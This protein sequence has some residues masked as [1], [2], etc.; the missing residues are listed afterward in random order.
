MKIVAYQ[1]KPA[2]YKGMYIVHSFIIIKGTV[3]VI[4][5]Y[6]PLMRILDSQW[7][8]LKFDLSRM[9]DISLLLY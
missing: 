1:K 7:F 3:S 6:L 9:S 2:F 5:S 4:L 8:P